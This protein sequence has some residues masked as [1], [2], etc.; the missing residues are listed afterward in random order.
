MDARELKDSA[1]ESFRKGKF[2][3]AAEAYLAL[4]K[5]EP[6]EFQHYIKL[7]DSYRR[8]GRKDAAIEAYREAVD[9]YARV[10]VMIKAIAACKLI[11]EIDP[12]HK[13]AQEALAQLC[14]QRYSS[15]MRRNEPLPLPRAKPAPA[16]EEIDLPDAEDS[17]ELDDGEVRK[18]LPSTRREAPKP[19]PV[20][21]RAAAPVMSQAAYVPKQEPDSIELEIDEPASAPPIAIDM[22]EEQS[23]IVLDFDLA[24]SVAMHAP[25]T[26]GSGRRAA[27]QSR[28]APSR[29]RGEAIEIGTSSAEDQDEIVVDEADLID[30]DE[31]PPGVVLITAENTAEHAVLDSAA[32]AAVQPSTEMA[33][34]LA[35]ASDPTDDFDFLSVTGQHAKTSPHPPLRASSV[36]TDDDLFTPT[37]PPAANEITSRTEAIAVAQLAED[38]AFDYVAA[39]PAEP[40]QEPAG[41]ALAIPSADLQQENVPLFSGLPKEA[42]ID[43]L[44]Q[45]TFRRVEAGDAILR[46]GDLGK[47]IF[48]LVSGHARVV[49]GL[50]TSQEIEL[51]KLEEG[52]FFGEM[53]LLNGAPRVASVLAAQDSEVLELTE[54]ILRDLTAKHPSVGQSLKKFYRQRLL[55]NVMAI[56]PLFRAFDKTDRKSLVEK[57]KLRELQKEERIIT[58]GQAPDGLYVIMHGAAL[59]TK[60][61]AANHR[62]VPLAALKEGD[63]FGEMSLLTRKPATASVTAKRK[64]LVLRLPKSTFDE[65]MFTHPAI[66]EVVSDLSDQRMRVNEQI[67]SGAVDIPSEAVAFL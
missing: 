32:S 53:A 27:D 50:G 21:V 31:L 45:M 30:D 63:V 10:G 35:R 57:F 7:G 9:G 26:A 22:P 55:A 41:P 6:K 54:E 51:A 11:L 8:E 58:E 67:L 56:S 65:L 52:A 24:P 16:L 14:A 18:P 4:T 29:R 15:T 61:D 40:E 43:L 17:L 12:A 47:S 42:F 44:E 23:E 60:N 48:V 1:S 28:P 36:P 49:R 66:L 39:A 62:I 19:Q 5:V 25:S 64:T 3:R 13:R 33:S 20:V 37:H 46:E 59:V 38:S 34:I 2:A